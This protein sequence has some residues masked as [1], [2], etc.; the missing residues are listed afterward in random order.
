MRGVCH[1]TPNLEVYQDEVSSLIVN[2]DEVCGVNTKLGEIFESKKSNHNNWYF[3]ERINS[4]WTK[5]L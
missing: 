1:N 5:Y 3:Y 2:E 4:Y